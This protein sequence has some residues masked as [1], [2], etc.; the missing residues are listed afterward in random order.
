M[1]YCTPRARGFLVLLLFRQLL[2][3]NTLYWGIP[4]WHSIQTSRPIR[5]LLCN[6]DAACFIGL[7]WTSS[8]CVN[9]I[10]KF[11]LLIVGSPRGSGCIAFI[12]SRS[13]EL[14]VSGQCES[15][16]SLG[17]LKAINSSVLCGCP[18]GGGLLGV[19]WAGLAPQ[20]LHFIRSTPRGSFIVD[21]SL[22]FH[23]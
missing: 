20:L 3:F 4:A 16:N 9:C 17:W 22:I 19:V 1:E 10:F 13:A 18:E 6:S 15:S 5:F 21:E 23:F 12:A 14:C 7:F 2:K 8:C 11:M